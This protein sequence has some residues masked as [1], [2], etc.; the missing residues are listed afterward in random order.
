MCVQV[1]VVIQSVIVCDDRLVFVS[2]VIA[3]LID[4]LYRLDID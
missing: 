4:D 1:N 3:D 2:F